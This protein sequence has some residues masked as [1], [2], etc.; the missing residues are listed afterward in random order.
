MVSAFLL[1]DQPIEHHL[2]TTPQATLG[3]M[4]ISRWREQEGGDV[5]Y[6][7]EEGDEVVAMGKAPRNLGERRAPHLPQHRLDPR[8]YPPPIPLR[9]HTPVLPP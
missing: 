2:A 1:V 3:T 4:A 5:R 9:Q 6:T 8:S 7:L